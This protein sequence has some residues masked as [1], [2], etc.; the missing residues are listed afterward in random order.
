MSSLKT[1]FAVLCMVVTLPAAVRADHPTEIRLF[2]E[3][4]GRLSASVEHAWLVGTDNAALRA[5]KDGFADLLD[6]LVGPDDSVRVMDW[7]VRAKM[8]HKRLL[9]LS[10]FATEPRLARLA[11]MRAQA[12]QNR[13]GAVLLG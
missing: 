5:Q 3:C 11:L 13:C 9:A 4:A 1:F 10:V 6:A 8:D 12:H 7:R 2:A